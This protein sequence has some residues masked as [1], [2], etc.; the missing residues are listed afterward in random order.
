MIRFASLF[1]PKA[2]AL[3]QS[4]REAGTMKSHSIKNSVIVH[5]AS[6]GEYEMAIPVIEKL[7]SQYA[8]R[9]IILSFFSHSGYEQVKN[10]HLADDICYLPEDQIGKVNDFLD[11]YDPSLFIFI[12][13][14]FWYILLE[15][16]N[17]RNV[18]F[19]LAAVKISGSNFIFKPYSKWFLSLIRNA[20]WI[21]TQDNESLDLLNE[22]GVKNCSK[23]GN[24]RLDRL[25][26]YT[27][28]TDNLSLIKKFKDGCLLI[29]A[30]SVWSEDLELIHTYHC[31]RPD[32]KLVI[33][34][35]EPNTKNLENI[36]KL[37]KDSKLC[38]SS[39]N[40]LSSTADI[41]I[42]DEVGWLKDCYSHADLAYIGG[43]FGKGIHN[44]LEVVVHGKAIFFGPNHSDFVEAVELSKLGVAKTVNSGNE[45][46]KEFDDLL[47]NPILQDQIKIKSMKYVSEN[48]NAAEHIIQK[49]ANLNV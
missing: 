41:L 22:F 10:S 31:S 33:A 28:N 46:L 19:I 35:H 6:L 9:K 17:N 43:G 32:V 1:D 16:L 42:L 12:K 11:L 47:A 3:I 14:E 38:F 23:S 8:D 34:P 27:A 5:C 48:Q 20:K 39:S 40:D 44:I 49:I 18:P 24:P 13:A 30:G 26:G 21:F 45:M 25:V 7:R 2:K 37:F 36:K 15:Q 29:I 4:R